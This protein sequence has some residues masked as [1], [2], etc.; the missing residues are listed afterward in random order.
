MKEKIVTA[1]PR[2]KFV[3]GDS[4][5]A[6]KT[7]NGHSCETLPPSVKKTDSVDNCSKRTKKM[8]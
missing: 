6:R 2:S 3:A 5:D 7:A 1:V 8:K 4:D